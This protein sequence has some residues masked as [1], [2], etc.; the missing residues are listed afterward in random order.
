M[1]NTVTETTTTPPTPATMKVFFLKGEQL[2]AVSRPRPDGETALGASLRS[3]FKGPTAAE[4]A[5]DVQTVIPAETRLTQVSIS[6]TGKAVV[7]VTKPFT[8]GLND[9]PEAAADSEL[10]G[11]LAQVVFTAQQFKDVKAAT[12]SVGGR[13]IATLT[14]ADYMR[15]ATPPPTPPTPRPSPPNRPPPRCPRRRTSRTS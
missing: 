7:A 6:A 3:L 9:L 5:D 2:A 15:P 11:R 4:Q 8:S 10:Q 14:D 12:V 1:T 13:T